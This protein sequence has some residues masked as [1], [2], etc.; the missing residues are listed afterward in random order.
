MLRMGYFLGLYLN[1]R[2]QTQ[3]KMMITIGGASEII[4]SCSGVICTPG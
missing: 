1:I 4:V 3:A 2:Y